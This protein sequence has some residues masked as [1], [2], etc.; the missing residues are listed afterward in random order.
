MG[1]KTESG[2]REEE[3]GKKKPLTLP[4]K[5][6]FSVSSD[7]DRGLVIVPRALGSAERDP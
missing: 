7:L 6:P 2:R 3:E 4:P 5:R 1:F